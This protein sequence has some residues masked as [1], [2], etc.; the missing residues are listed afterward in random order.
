M[1]ER[2]SYCEGVK[3][4]KYSTRSPYPPRTG[5]SLPTY[6]KYGGTPPRARPRK[7]GMGC[8]TL[9]KHVHTPTHASPP[10]CHVT[11]RVPSHLWWRRTIGRRL[12]LLSSSILASS[13]IDVF[14]IRCSKRG[15]L[16]LVAA[17]VA[18][19]CASCFIVFG[20]IFVDVVVVFFVLF[21]CQP[22]VPVGSVVRRRRRRR[23]GGALSRMQHETAPLER[24]E[25]RDG[26]SSRGEQSTP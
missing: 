16:F 6:T 13:K 5:Q 14:A 4:S 7:M 11:Q 3:H 19:C 23:G 10:H 26:G 17:L 18:C 2:F 9:E 25:P 21:L 15:F 8:P 1:S 12:L 24:G 20:R 22:N